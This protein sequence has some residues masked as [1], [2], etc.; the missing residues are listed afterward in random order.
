MIHTPSKQW[1]V[2]DNTVKHISYP[3][4]SNLKTAHPTT[5]LGRANASTPVED[6]VCAMSVA[7]FVDI[8]WYL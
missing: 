3:H 2:C 6:Q 8:M 4:L 1:G 5:C 7:M